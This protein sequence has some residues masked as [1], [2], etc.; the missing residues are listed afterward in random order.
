ML[1]YSVDLA[2]TPLGEMY[3]RTL[4][5]MIPEHARSA[6]QRLVT[7]LIALLCGLTLCARNDNA[8]DSIATELE[9]PALIGGDRNLFLHK[10]TEDH[11][12]TFCLEFY[13]PYKMT[14]WVANQ[15]HDGN[16]PIIRPYFSLYMFHDLLPTAR[17]V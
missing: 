1:D 4:L 15:L 13:T 17:D 6:L 12:R 3:Q 7:T 2:S 10:T 14:R 11:G 16:Y 8:N 5:R 9:C